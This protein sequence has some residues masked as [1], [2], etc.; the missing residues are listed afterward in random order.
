MMVKKTLR[1][2]GGAG[3][4]VCAP[5]DMQALEFR[6]MFK[7]PCAPVPLRA[8]LQ[9]VPRPPSLIIPHLACSPA[10]PQGSTLHAD[11]SPLPFNFILGVCEQPERPQ[12]PCTQRPSPRIPDLPERAAPGGQGGCAEGWRGAAPPPP[13]ALPSAARRGPGPGERESLAPAAI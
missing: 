3:A 9:P 8:I 5:L 4:R 12:R 11:V 13:P 7:S 2:H 6:H 10:A 1:L